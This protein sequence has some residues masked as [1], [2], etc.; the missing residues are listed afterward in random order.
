MTSMWNSDRVAHSHFG[1]LYSIKAMAKEPLADEAEIEGVC[2]HCGYHLRHTAA[3]LRR[4]TPIVCPNRGAQV[5]PPPPAASA[6]PG[7][8]LAG[9]GKRA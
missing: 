1:P 3:R 4:D 9:A 7:D 5:V 8:V 6:D 2:R